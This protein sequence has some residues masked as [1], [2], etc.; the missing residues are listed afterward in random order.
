MQLFINVFLTDQGLLSYNRGLLKKHTKP[1]VFKYMLASMAVIPFSNVTIHYQLDHLYATLY[2]ELDSYILRFFPNAKISHLRK[3]NQRAWRQALEEVFAH[4]DPIVWFTCNDDHIFWDADL[5]TLLAIES[6][7]L[8]LYRRGEAATCNF[9]HWPENIRI[10]ITEDRGTHGIVHAT[11]DDSIQVMNTHLLREWFFNNEYGELVI[12][13]TDAIV[14]T[15]CTGILP[16][17]ELARHFDG[18]S[19]VGVSIDACPP[20]DIPVGFFEKDLRIDYCPTS[21][22]EG[23][24]RLDPCAPFHSTVNPSGAD[25]KGLLEDL[26]L[27][28][29][30][31]ISACRTG[32][33]EA[34]SHLNSAR[35]VAKLTLASQ[36]LPPKLARTILA[37]DPIFR[38][39]PP[40]PGTLVNDHVGVL[41]KKDYSTSPRKVSI[42]ILSCLNLPYESLP[43]ESLLTQNISRDRY[44]VICVALTPFC[45]HNK[46]F[47]ADNSDVYIEMNH[48][49]DIRNGTFHRHKGFNLGLL[50]ARGDIVCFCHGCMIFPS[51]FVRKTIEAIT[52]DN[53]A[54]TYREFVASSANPE[55]ARL[56]GMRWEPD[57]DL[58][59]VSVS[60]TTAL[61]ANGFNEDDAYFGLVGGPHEILHRL[62][63]S[64]IESKRVAGIAIRRAHTPFANGVKNIKAR[65]TQTFK[66]NPHFKRHAEGSF[67]N[68]WP[69][70][71]P[72]M[73]VEEDRNEGLL[74][75]LCDKIK[76]AEGMAQSGQLGRAR[77]LA[78]EMT[79]LYPLSPL[80]LALAAFIEGLSMDSQAAL[81]Y[82]KRAMGLC[83]QERNRLS[84]PGLKELYEATAMKAI[85][86]HDKSMASYLVN[87]LIEFYP[88]DERIESLERLLAIKR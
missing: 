27:F 59:C 53:Y 31:R 44:E 64:G 20:L 39:S 67:F 37:K 10:P 63:E 15:N 12:R 33:D 40:K 65:Q 80:P 5:D 77:E 83:W 42:I 88:G 3:D 47:F 70:E 46:K 7:L 62:I 74:V 51:N 85:G 66:S 18:Y 48:A 52:D 35:N 36:L 1:D 54:I 14:R 11:W 43:L 38:S 32:R 68:S 30:D 22:E 41:I 24:V 61:S 17:R 34:P 73:W 81:V 57:P 8:D 45:W 21:L 50:A 78:Q 29:R 79:T 4:E 23:W 28:W 6:D 76:V 69:E 75:E 56:T 49:G 25:I 71:H 26:P 60:R 55:N 19:H 9:S 16:Y 82:L 86:F 2:H 13:R 58:H 72:M 87:S 84:L